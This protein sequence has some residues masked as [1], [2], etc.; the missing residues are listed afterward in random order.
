VESQEASEVRSR[1]GN[2]VD[3]EKTCTAAGVVLRHCCR[4][5]HTIVNY[6]NFFLFPRLDVNKN[7]EVEAEA[8]SASHSPLCSAIQ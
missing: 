8:M 6:F 5:Y 7:M 4:V 1:A 3:A 2:G